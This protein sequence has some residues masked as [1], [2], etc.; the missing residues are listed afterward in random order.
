MSLLYA[1][2]EVALRS[3]DL[4]QAVGCLRQARR[5][6]SDAGAPFVEA[7]AA[8]ALGSLLV[9]TGEPGALGTLRQ[10]LAFWRRAAAWPQI[11]TTARLVAEHCAGRGGDETALLLL[12][13]AERDPRAPLVTGRDADRHRLLRADARAR[14]GPATAERLDGLARIMTPGDAVAR[15]VTAATATR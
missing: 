12:A 5:V 11:W 15:A 9:R 10:A 4:E 14:M 7:L 13:L 3:D 6:A 2:D 8:T 1:A